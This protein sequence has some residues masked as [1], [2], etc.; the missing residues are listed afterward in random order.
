MLKNKYINNFFMWVG[1]PTHL[2][3]QLVV[4]WA[5]LQNFW[6]TIKWVGLGLLIFNPSRGEP[7]R[8]SRIGSLSHV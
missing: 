3:Q 1:E 4:G 6:F 7:I 2:T 8:V 5:R